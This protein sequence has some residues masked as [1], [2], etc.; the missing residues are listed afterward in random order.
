MKAMNATVTTNN[1][2]SHQAKRLGLSDFWRWWSG[3]LRTALSPVI[4]KW[5]ADDRATTDVTSDG[6][7]LNVAGANAPGIELGMEDAAARRIAIEDALRNRGRDLRVLLANGLALRKRVRYPQ[8]TEE[9]LREVIA[10]DMDRQ[11]PFSAEQVAYD[12]RVVSRDA[13]RGTIE[14]ELA[15]IPKTALQ[16][17][18]VPLREAGCTIH[19]VGIEGDTISPPIEFLAAAEKPARQFSKK[20]RLHLVLL[21]GAVLMILLAVAVPI[22]QKARAVNELAPQVAKAETEAEV[23]RRVESEY[24]KL[25]QEY[26]FL[27]GRKH[28]TLPTVVLI[29]ELSKLSPDTT[30]LTRLE[31]KTTTKVREVQLEGE[32]VS[33]SKM[34]ELLEQSTLLQNASQRAQ[35]TRGNQPNTERFSIASEIKPRPMPAPMQVAGATPAVAPVVP[36]VAP[37]VAAPTQAPVTPTASTPAKGGA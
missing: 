19:A 33:A 5:L 6:R 32:A 31:V 2:F 35:T 26:N 12:A 34:I 21:V 36:V 18:L 22:V 24:Q 30:W 9:N 1:W 7:T 27:T 16:A 4:A 20:Q 14:V 10:F 8:A 29:E 13:E 3:E 28:T 17:V 23:T 37:P 11:T 15:L 25:A